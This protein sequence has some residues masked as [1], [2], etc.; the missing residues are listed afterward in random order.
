MKNKLS[1]V[2]IFR[3]LCFWW[4][5]KLQILWHDHRHECTLEDALSI[6]FFRF[7]GSIKMKLGQVLVHLMTNISNWFVTLLWRLE[8]GFRPFYNSD[9]MTV[10]CNLFIFSWW[11]FH[12]LIVSV[13]T[14][15]K[16]RNHKPII[17]FFIVVGW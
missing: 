2:G 9:K 1:F 17:I 3:F 15:K 5:Q 4:M 7:L 11:S 6:F 14:F 10:Q 16:V 12:F 8:T 13:H